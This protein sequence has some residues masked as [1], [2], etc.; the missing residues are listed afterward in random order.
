MSTT[1][2]DLASKGRTE[3]SWATT[4]VSKHFDR[5]GITTKIENHPTSGKLQIRYS[6]Y[7][8]RS[9]IETVDRYLKKHNS[10]SLEEELKSLPIRLAPAVSTL[11]VYRTYPRTKKELAEMNNLTQEGIKDFLQSKYYYIGKRNSSMK[12]SK[13]YIGFRIEV[14]MLPLT[15]LKETNKGVAMYRSLIV[16]KLSALYRDLMLELELDRDKL[17]LY[18][19]IEAEIR[20]EDEAYVKNEFNPQSKDSDISPL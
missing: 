4:L 16:K 8:N 15:N 11:S 10:S 7:I 18:K 12:F 3:Y 9:Y 20:K 2:W 14:P 5:F 13:P 19:D 6:F 1:L 17:K